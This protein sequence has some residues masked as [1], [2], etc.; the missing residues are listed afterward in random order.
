MTH[1]F[2][3]KTQAGYLSPI[4]I[5]TSELVGTA[6]LTFMILAT[7]DKHNAAP[8]LSLLPIAVFI[9]VLSLGVSWGMESMCDLS[10]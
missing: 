5:F 1:F 2:N 6:I 4:P 8:D 3:E 9:I 7:T 10:A